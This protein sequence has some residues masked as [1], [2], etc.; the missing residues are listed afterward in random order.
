MIKNISKI[1]SSEKNLIEYLNKFLIP[2][3]SDLNKTKSNF[4]KYLKTKIKWNKNFIVKL[5]NVIDE[6]F[7]LT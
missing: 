4:I 1:I 5:I 3:N 6:D 7:K 2:D